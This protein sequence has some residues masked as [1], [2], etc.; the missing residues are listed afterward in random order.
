MKY[1]RFI[2]LTS[3]LLCL[4]CQAGNPGK[5]VPST[6]RA[7]EKYATPEPGTYLR[8]MAYALLK[9]INRRRLEP[10]KYKEPGD[11][12]RE[13]FSARQKRQ[14]DTVVSRD[15]LEVPVRIYYP[16]RKSLQG[17]CPLMLFIH[18]GGFIIGSVDEYHIM[19][20]KL[21]RVTNQVIVSV[22]YRLAPRHPFPAGLNDC[23]AVLCWLQEHARELGADPERI[24][25]MGDSAGG[26]LATVLTL[27]CRDEGRHQPFRQ[28]LV[29]PGVSFPDTTYP[30][31]EYFARSGQ[32]FLLTETFMQKA[33]DSYIPEGTDP[34]HPYISPLRATLGP[35][36]APALV[37]TA[38]CDPIRDGGRMYAK[39]LEESGVEVKHIE[40]SGM[41]HGF[42]SFHMIF[43]EAIDAMK[44]IRDYLEDS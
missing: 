43:S 42:M 35:E 16:S 23:F 26:N 15:G 20:S 11:K 8:P 44:D 36:L 6:A 38:E 27:R 32:F 24:S 30:S 1:A 22:G 2:L 34:G 17:E 5:Y 14:L 41:I 33:R 3:L 37:I 21:A 12:V 19:V 28:V 31:L 10:E 7:R 4:G 25:V 13:L 39:R 40:Y 18:G 29:Y 9:E